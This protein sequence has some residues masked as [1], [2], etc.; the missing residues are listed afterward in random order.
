VPDA[1]AAGNRF[2]G[3][4]VFALL[5]VRLGLIERPERSEGKEERD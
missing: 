3:L 2:V 4:G 1:F 5:L